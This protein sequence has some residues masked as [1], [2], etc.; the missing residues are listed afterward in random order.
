MFCNK[1]ILF[2]K[3]FK[4]SNHNNHEMGFAHDVKILKQPVAKSLVTCII[5]NR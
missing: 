2:K 3:N 4:Q 1:K 5:N